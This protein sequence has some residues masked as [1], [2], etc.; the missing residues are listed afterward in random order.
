MAK[1]RIFLVCTEPTQDL[2]NFI[3]IKV[4]AQGNPSAETSYGEEMEVCELE[5]QDTEAAD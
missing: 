2:S 3:V 4:D 1:P 5:E